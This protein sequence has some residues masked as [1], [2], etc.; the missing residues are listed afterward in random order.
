MK[1]TQQE[2]AMVVDTHA[3]IYSF[4]SFRNLSPYIRTMEDAIA[5]R[6]RH[7]DVYKC[8]LTEDPEDNTADLISDMDKHGVAFSLVQ[9][10]AGYVSND[11]VA[12]AAAK[13]PDRVAP[14]A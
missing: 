3:H 4:P 13:W 5:F 9:A 11:L 14:L 1:I 7:P 6:T 10:R 2:T 12:E 8:N